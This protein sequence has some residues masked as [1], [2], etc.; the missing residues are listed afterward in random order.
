[1]SSVIEDI[2][3]RLNE[4]ETLDKNDSVV[5]LDRVQQLTTENKQLKQAAAQ[6]RYLWRDN[7]LAGMFE[8][9]EEWKSEYDEC[10][11]EEK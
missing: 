1:V 9:F 7:L 10:R 11:E 4:G 6:K 8:H 5:L 3:Q 2:K